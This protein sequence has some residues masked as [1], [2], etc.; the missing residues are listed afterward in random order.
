VTNLDQKLKTDIEKYLSDGYAVNGKPVKG[1][2][3]SSLQMFLRDSEGWRSLGSFFYD[4]VE[5]LG[6]KIGPAESTVKGRRGSR[7]LVYRA[8]EGI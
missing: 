5:K 7:E 2:P 8:V 3:M 6:F 1:Q 4:R